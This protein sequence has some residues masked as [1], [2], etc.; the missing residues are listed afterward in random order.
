MLHLEK[1]DEYKDQATVSHL[2]RVLALFFRCFSS[3]SPNYKKYSNHKVYS[4]LPPE[5]IF[6]DVNHPKKLLEQKI[7]HNMV[8]LIHFSLCSEFKITHYKILQIWF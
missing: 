7:T 1:I 2:L 5:T 8:K 6:Y 4:I 3:I